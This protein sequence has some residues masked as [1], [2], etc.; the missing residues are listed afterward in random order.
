SFYLPTS[1]FNF[2][3][4]CFEIV[5]AD[6]QIATQMVVTGDEPGTLGLTTFGDTATLSGFIGDVSG[7]TVNFTLYGPYAAD[8]VPTCDVGDVA[9][10]TSGTLNANGVATATDTFP[11]T[12]AGTYVWR[13]SY[14]VQDAFNSAAIDPCNE[15]TEK[16]SVE[17]ATVDISKSANPA[18]PISAGDT[19]GF[20][21]TFSASA[22]HTATDV[23]ITDELPAGADLNWSLVPP[24]AGCVINGPVG[25]QVLTCDIGTVPKG[26]IAGP[27]HLESATTPADCGVVVN[28]VSFTAGNA[29]GGGDSATV[30]VDC[31]DPGL[32]KTADAA[33]APLGDSIGFTVHVT[34]AGPGR[35]IAAVIDDPL[36]AGPGI[37]WSISPAYAGPGTCVI[38]TVNAVQVLH[39]EFGDLAADADVPVHVSSATNST[40]CGTY[41]NTATLTS[42]N[43][44]SL[45]ATASTHLDCPAALPEAPLANTGAGPLG[46]EISWAIVFILGGGLLVGFGSRRRPSQR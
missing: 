42:S 43:A 41:D 37:S 25:T 1:H 46:A 7:E 44:P 32:T 29:P 27:I 28:S 16:A 24:I 12:Q 3:T 22:A 4:E 31:P 18:G 15:A 5:H 17:G 13:A 38:N 20:D 35:L 26:A 23:V 34:N 11:P 10:T 14:D 30:V 39:C 8:E 21:I 36:P 2:D 40:S 6:P 45:S 33:T 19:I 9:F